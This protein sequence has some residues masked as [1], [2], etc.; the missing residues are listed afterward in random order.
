[1]KSSTTVAAST[2]SRRWTLV[3]VVL[4]SASVF[5]DSTVVNVALP[6]IGR[7]LPAT[8][9]GVLEGQSYVYN[10][11]LLTLSTLL[12]PAGALGDHYGRRKI[13]AIGLA[14]FALTSLLCGLA[15]SMEALIVARI[16]QGAAGALLVPE[17]LAL[18]RANFEG[19][20]QGRAIGTWAATSSATTLLGPLVAGLLVDTLSW[21][22]AFLINLPL[23][24]FAAWALLE[25]TP[26]SRDDDPKAHLDWLGAAI[27]GVA[28]GG[29]SFGT[30][31]GQQRAWHGTAEYIALALGAAALVALP[32]ELAR[33]RT[34][35]VP[36]R[37]FRSR[38][39]TVV[40]LVT[41][42]VY[43]ALYVSGYYQTLFLQGVLGYSAAA[44]GLAILPGSLLLALFSRRM[45]QLSVRYGVRTFLAAGA[46]VMA[47]GTLWLARAPVGSAAWRLQPGHP[48]SWIPSPG[49]LVDI[50]PSSLLFGVG[51]ALLVAPLTS[52]LMA[53]APAANAGV[54]S[55]VNNAISRVGPQLGGALVFIGVTALFRTRV[56]D[57]RASPL[58]PPPAGLS[59]NLVN[60]ASTDAFHLAA[61]FCAALLLTGALLA[62]AGLRTRPRPA[63]A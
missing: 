56:G 1:M 5:L 63:P 57:L 9:V 18:I 54:A 31:Y 35:L 11:Y 2:M 53:S 60:A 58:N 17:S 13:F 52:A 10:A 49:Y 29:L 41:F 61:V 42:V 12:I 25:H 20:D 28:V 39:F 47:V 24:A 30:I 7:D 23:L 26:E 33:S 48:A 34:P 55:A 3:A 32:F 51:L 38:D 62:W 40:N 8:Y 37:L 6:R 15:P 43:G 59:K 50:L 45:G 19:E 44:A 4:G 36:L 46:T 22:V 21:R 27:S 14:G 16:L